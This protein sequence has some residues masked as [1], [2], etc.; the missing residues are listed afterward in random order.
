MLQ[1]VSHQYPVGRIGFSR[2]LATHQRKIF[3]ARV[4]ELESLLAILMPNRIIH[5]R[6]DTDVAFTW[7]YF[8]VSISKGNEKCTNLEL[9][10]P[11]V[12]DDREENGF[13]G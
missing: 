8:R 3:F 5:K 7:E 11:G 13:Y 1:L 12:G 10:C 6:M 9:I 2:A 4:G